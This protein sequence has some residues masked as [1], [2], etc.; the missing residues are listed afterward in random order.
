[1]KS[2]IRC[3]SE[4]VKAKK[5]KKKEDSDGEV[6]WAGGRSTVQAW[7]DGRSEKGNKWEARLQ[8]GS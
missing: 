4:P 7:T 8:H 3:S 6:G 5:K 2:N 1:M